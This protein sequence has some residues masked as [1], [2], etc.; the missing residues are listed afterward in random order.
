MHERASALIEMLG[1]APH[2]EGGYFREV[3]RSQLKVRPEDGRPPR[4]SLTTIY[5]L[6][7]KGQVSTWHRV[8]A[9]EA[10][11][12]CEGDPLE[13]TWIDQAKRRVVRHVLAPVAEGQAPVVVVPA[14]CW[15]L[16]WPLGAYTLV[17]CTVGPGFEYEDWE[18]L[19]L[20][21]P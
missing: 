21:V 10:W 2:P 5:F 17:G 6:L 12:Y 9:D 3:F 4:A 18:L 13:L 16:A 19:H 8:A 20:G 11:H 15:Q 7:V 1:L 14:G